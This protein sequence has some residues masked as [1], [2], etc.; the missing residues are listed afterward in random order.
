MHDELDSD[1]IAVI[2]DRFGE[3]DSAIVV[4]LPEK[5]EE[6]A[7]LMKR[8]DGLKDRFTIIES[9]LEGSG[10]LSLTADERAGLAE[11]MEVVSFMEDIERKAIYFAGHRDCMKY[12]KTIGAI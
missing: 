12:L 11:Y 1:L 7:G 6:Y 3:M 9:W 8:K 2:S 5:D 4:A 10:P